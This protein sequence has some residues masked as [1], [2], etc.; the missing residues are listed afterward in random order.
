MM[1]GTQVPAVRLPYIVLV[2]LYYSIVLCSV[3]YA[4]LKTF[5]MRRKRRGGLG[6]VPPQ[7]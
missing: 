4:V 3:L 6:G 1:L 5:S 7:Q 2:H